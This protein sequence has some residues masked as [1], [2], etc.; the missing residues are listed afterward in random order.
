MRDLI[1]YCLIITFL[2]TLLNLLSGNGSD[3]AYGTTHF[4]D[5]N[6]QYMVHF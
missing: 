2:V 5:L 4:V 1:Y 6:Y 3:S